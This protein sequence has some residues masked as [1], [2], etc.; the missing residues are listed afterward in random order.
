MADTYNNWGDEPPEDLLPME[1]IGFQDQQP[2]QTGSL[3]FDINPFG[4]DNAQQQIPPSLE[5][6]ISNV[7]AETKIEANTENRS[8]RSDR[9]ERSK[10]SSRRHRR[11]RSRDKESSSSR[12]KSS[13]RDKDRDRK[14]SRSRSK[15]RS[16]RR[17]SRSRSKDKDRKKGRGGRSI[18]R[19][20][21][22]SER[23]VRSR[24]GG[25]DSRRGGRGGGYGG[26]DYHRES[27][28][29]PPDVL[30]RNER[31]IFVRGLADH[32]TQSTLLEVPLFQNAIDVKM[33]INRDGTGHKGF[34]HVTFA[35]KDEVTQAM[36]NFDQGGLR[37]L[38]QSLYIDY[39]GQQAR[40]NPRDRAEKKDRTLFLRAVPYAATEAD[41]RAHPMFDKCSLL[42]MARDD[43][44]G[45]F[46]GFAHVEYNTRYDAEGAMRIYDREGLNICGK[47]CFIDYT[48]G[49]M[50]DGDR[51][52]RKRRTLFVRSIP[53]DATEE[54]IKTVPCFR[55]SVD[56]RMA[57]DP[58]TGKFRGFCH[59]EFKTQG[60]AD[61]A[62]VYYDARGINILGK[63][64]H[65][66]YV[67]DNARQTPEEKEMARIKAEQKRQRKRE[68]DALEKLLT[69]NSTAESAGSAAAS[70]GLN[71]LDQ[72]LASAKAGNNVSAAKP[73][74]N[75]AS[76]SNMS[77][78]I[79]QNNRHMSA[80]QSG[81]VDGGRNAG[82]GGKFDPY[83]HANNYQ[84][85]QNKGG[86][87]QWKSQGGGGYGG[88][89]WKG[90]QNNSYNKS[91]DGGNF[92][93]S[94]NESG[95]WNNNSSGGWGN[96]QA[97]EP[98]KKKP[99]PNMGG[100][101]M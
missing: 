72:L 94:W 25:R 74:P 4:S 86:G 7:K 92:N 47:K 24:I 58:N 54:L 83:Q 15:D 31:M 49:K 95:G 11:S 9:K 8:E 46:R 1:N 43:K 59:V 98:P 78:G 60:E 45:S 85:N 14:R 63:S 21:S 27:R 91:N 79:S 19:T 41:I 57:K 36:R 87:G 50:T 62:M 68:S 81:S 35:T 5:N 28:G 88:G 13:K 75:S 26:N 77:T 2:P 52:D 64:V 16:R 73:K 56:I 18:F 22:P 84:N 12:H 82:R 55:S 10:D 99:N 101:L 100:L 70:A 3:G 38:G 53:Y 65:S 32:M 69:Q 30:E 44:D 20:P 34:C 67:G 40:Q 93:A 51:E 96:S 61:A 17:R 66:D 71:A 42:K 80:L 89:Q 39:V 33:S 6:L 48:T 23:N 29:P 37:V 76:I 97:Q 90:N